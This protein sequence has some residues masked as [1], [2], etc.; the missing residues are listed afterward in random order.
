MSDDDLRE[1]EAARA[2]WGTPCPPGELVTRI[3]AMF[4]ENIR[5]RRELAQAELRGR[6]AELERVIDAGTDLSDSADY[7]IAQERL[8]ELKAQVT[9]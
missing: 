4:S 3:A 6:I 7:R 5:L 1:L 9:E 2:V 8:A